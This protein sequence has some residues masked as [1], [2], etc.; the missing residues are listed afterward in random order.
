MVRILAAAD[1]HGSYDIAKSLAKK[2]AKYNV[3]LVVLAGD[4]HG[5]REGQGFL[6][7]PFIQEN[8]KVLFIP[9]NWDSLEEHERLRHKAKSIHRYY[10]TYDG[11]GIAGIGSPNM[12]FRLDE[13]DFLEIKRLFNKMKPEKKILVSHLHARGTKA[14]FSGVEGDEI[15]RR[16][17]EEFEPDILLSAHIHE[18]EGIEDR[19]GKTRVFQVGRRGKIF[20]I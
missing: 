4:L 9:G 18:G 3:D 19:I 11:V 12:K 16:A 5:H 8:K 15:I 14:E 7:D 6:L 17:V 1:F 20:E 13:D 2:A 10:V